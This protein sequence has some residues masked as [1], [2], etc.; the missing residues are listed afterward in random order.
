[1]KII[2]S[3]LFVIFLCGCTSYGPWTPITALHEKS[4]GIQITVYKRTQE[5]YFIFP[6]I[7]AIPDQTGV[8]SWDGKIIAVDGFGWSD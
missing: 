3:L 2:T 6:M 5:P 4:R 7:V 1:M 8:Q